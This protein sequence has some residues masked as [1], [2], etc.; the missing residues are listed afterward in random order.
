M[1]EVRGFGGAYEERKRDF[2]LVGQSL[3]TLPYQRYLYMEHVILGATPQLPTFRI[4]LLPT[5][6]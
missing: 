4:S 5:C 3:P 2:W 1:K 6:K